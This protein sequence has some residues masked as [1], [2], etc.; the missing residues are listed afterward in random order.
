LV[1]RDSLVPYTTLFR[2][3][4][5]GRDRR[6]GSAGLQP[7]ACL[8]AVAVIAQVG[9]RERAGGEI[10]LAVINQYR[11]GIFISALRH[12]PAGI[13][14]HAADQVGVVGGDLAVG[15]V[16]DQQRALLAGD[17]AVAI[18]LAEA[19]ATAAALRYAET[20][21]AATDA[22]VDAHA[23][24]FAV[25]GILQAFNGQGPG[26]DVRAVGV[27]HGTTQRQ[28]ITAA[29]EVTD[30]EACVD[31]LGGATAAARFVVTGARVPAAASA[32]ADADAELA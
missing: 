18:A 25:L 21:H 1:A 31:V 16:G 22:G 4:A 32:A 19:A 28:G 13:G 8:A 5:D 29:V 14:D 26:S 2:S 27:H 20:G 15:T 23:A 11:C 24:V 6:A 12:F 30:M 9:R 3:L 10:Q 7:E 17:G